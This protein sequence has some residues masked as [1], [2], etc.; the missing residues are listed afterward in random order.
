[1]TERHKNALGILLS[2]AL[3]LVVIL[4]C[5]CDAHAANRFDVKVAKQHRR[6]ADTTAGV[7]LIKAQTRRHFWA[8]ADHV[9][10]PLG[11]FSPGGIIRAV[12]VH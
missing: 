11:W 6:Q 8:T 7:T 5:G 3:M 12:F 1:M 4:L 10:T 2:I 9:T